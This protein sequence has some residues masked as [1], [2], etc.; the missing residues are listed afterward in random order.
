MRSNKKNILLSIAFLAASQMLHSDDQL[1]KQNATTPSAMNDQMVITP[2]AG[3][4]VKHGADIFVDADFIYW[5]A[6]QDGLPYVYTGKITEDNFT[7]HPAV[8][9]RLWANHSA[10]VEKSKL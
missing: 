3:P 10:I 4:V 5:T 6:R 1:N 9:Q 2:S 7:P 8:D